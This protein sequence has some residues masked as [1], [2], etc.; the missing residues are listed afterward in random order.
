MKKQNILKGSIILMVSAVV[1]KAFG[2]LFKIPLTNLLGGVGMSYFSCAYS[3]FLP[4]YALTATGLS[5][6]VARMTARSAALGMYGNIIRIRRIALLMF[7]AVGL[8]GS[9]AVYLL[10]YPFS[11][12]STGGTEAVPAVLMIAPAVLFGCV[13]AVERGYYEGLSNMYPTALSQA[14]EGALKVAAGLWLCGFVNSH[15]SIIMARFPSVTDIRALSAAAGILGV[16]LSSLGAAVF[17]A[18]L[19]LF[20]RRPHGGEEHVQSR[21]EI[22]RE[23]AL[24]SL[25]VGISSVVTNLTAIVDMWTMI[26]CISRFGCGR[27]LPAA[28]AE[29]DIPNFV[30]GSFAGIALTVFNL[31]P[32]V[33]NML[34]KGALPAITAAWAERDRAALEAGTSQALVTAAALSVPSA[35]G[36]GVLSRGVLNLLFPLQSDEVEICISALRLLMPGMVCL[37][38]SFPVFSLLQAVG[39][40]SAPLKVMLMGTAVKL[41]GNLALVPLMG[42]DGAAVSTSVCYG[43]ILAAALTV[44]VRTTRAGLPVTP[45]VKIVYAGAMCGG[46]AYLADGICIRMGADGAAAVLVSIGAGAALYLISLGLLSL[47]KPKRAASRHIHADRRSFPPRH[48]EPSAAADTFKSEFRIMNS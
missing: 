38:L 22:A 43:A 35:F 3:L 19:A 40:P 36:L 20:T 6:A 18:L 30:Y 8:L 28:V 24:T 31:V 23:L 34:G 12:L 33:T 13:T 42:A 15:G 26:A 5:S 4:V 48:S 16:S 1:A 29:A 21:R 10:A 37:C 11:R 47:K 7:T 45:L 46:G 39:K 44:Y 25:P 32:S 2:A 27:E 41:V 9:A 14:A 17:F